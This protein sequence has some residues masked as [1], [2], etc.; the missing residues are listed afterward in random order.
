MHQAFSYN[1]Y[2]IKPHG[3]SI[4]GKL[5]IFNPQDQPV[6][7]IEHKTRWSKPFSVFHAYADEKKKQELLLIQNGEHASYSD[8]FTVTDPASAEPVGGF[9]VDWKMFF[10]DAWG[11]VDAQGAIIGQV[12]ERSTGRAIL[13]ELTE[14]VIPQVLDITIGGQPVAELR[15]KAVMLGHHLLVDFSP[16]AA[17]RLDRRL[18][19]AIAILIAAHQ[20]ETGAE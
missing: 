3:L 13:H 1:Q 19:L 7:F 16:D 12:S 8:Y 18:G 4:A 5:R 11:I 10:E 20:A 17:G 14:G 6:V 15:Q 9:G 2:V